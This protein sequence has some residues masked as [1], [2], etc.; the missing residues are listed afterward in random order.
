MTPKE[1][2][3]LCK[4]QQPS[5]AFLF[6]GPE[7]YMKSRC[8]ALL[9]QSVLGK[10]DDPFNHLKISAE[11]PDWQERLADAVTSLPMFAEKKLVELH[12]V[13]YNR[14]SSSDSEQLLGL[15]SAL[16]ELPSLPDFPSEEDGSPL[17]EARAEEAFCEGVR[18]AVCEKFSLEESEVSVRTEGFDVAS[19]R[20][21]R[22]C[23]LLKG[24]GTLSDTF[25]I[26]SFVEAEGLG[27][28]E[29]EIE[30]GGS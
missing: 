13:N 16:P 5:G 14:L 19:M 12:S 24:K 28:C 15:L 4:T 6:F 11:H 21:Q 3:K 2:Q 29:V 7:E 10:E 26:A 30:F 18:A 9:K 23:I 20:A 22:I 1:L 25:S 17:Y 27:E 8:L